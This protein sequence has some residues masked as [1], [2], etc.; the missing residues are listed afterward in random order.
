MMEDTAEACGLARV[1]VVDELKARIFLGV[2]EFNVSPF[3]F[4]WNRFDLG[5]A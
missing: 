4:P 3:N 1:V 2:E 5:E